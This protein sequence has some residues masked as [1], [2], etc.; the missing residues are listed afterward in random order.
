MIPACSI[1]RLVHRRLLNAWCLFDWS[2][3]RCVFRALE[4]LPE[5]SIE[6]RVCTSSTPGL[7]Y[8]EAEA[9]RVRRLRN[10]EALGSFK[11]AVKSL[12]TEEQLSS[13][14][15]AIEFRKPF[16]LNLR[17]LSR[18]SQAPQL[19]SPPGF[20]KPWL[21]YSLAYMPPALAICI[22]ISDVGDA[23]GIMSHAHSSPTSNP[24]YSP[25]SSFVA[26]SISQ[27]HHSCLSRDRQLQPETF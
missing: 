20:V 23:L 17:H 6:S 27:N 7:L 10:Q 18:S 21:A 4:V 24:S 25:L 9:R 5:K 15:R 19:V 12:S 26:C 14:V 1:S 11:G 13:S 22:T 16:K 2:L 3:F 8:S